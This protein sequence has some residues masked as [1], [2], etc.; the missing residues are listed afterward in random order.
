MPQLSMSRKVGQTKNKLQLQ[1][2]YVGE[3]KDESYIH[4]NII[5]VKKKNDC[6]SEAAPGYRTKSISQNRLDFNEDSFLELVE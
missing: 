5:L 3:R 4:V 6:T 1:E 2:H